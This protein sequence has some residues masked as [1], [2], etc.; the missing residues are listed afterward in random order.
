[1]QGM[2]HTHSHDDIAQCLVTHCESLA[3]AAAAACVL[4]NAQI[5]NAKCGY[6]LLYQCLLEESAQEQ[7]E[8]AQ[9]AQT[10]AKERCAVVL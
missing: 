5:R 9:P 6:F 10:N 4:I 2:T 8:T 1:M 3:Q 7:L